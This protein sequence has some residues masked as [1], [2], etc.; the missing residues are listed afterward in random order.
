M[1]S[2][3]SPPFA[4][5]HPPGTSFRLGDFLTE[6]GAVLR[7][8]VL[9]YRLFGDVAEAPVRGWRLAF[10]DLG[11]SA[12]LD[13]WWP[14]LLAPGAPLDPAQG[15]VL[16]VNL[17]GSGLG[18]TGPRD[19]IGDR[20]GAFPDLTPADLARAHEPVLQHLGVARITLAIGPSLGGMVALE[21]AVG[22]PY[23]PIIWSSS[24][25]PPRR[26]RRRSRGILRSEWPSRPIP[27][28]K[29]A[30]TSLAMG[31]EAGMAAARALALI[32]RGSGPEFAGRSARPG[33]WPGGRFAGALSPRARPRTHH[34]RRR[35]LRGTAARD[36]SS[37]PGRPRERGPRTA[38]RVRRVTG[39][40]I[41]TD[42]LVPPAEVRHWESAYP[43]AGI[44]AGRRNWPRSTDTPPTNDAE[45]LTRIIAGI[46]EVRCDREAT[47]GLGHVAE[48]LSCESVRLRSR[49]A[50]APLAHPLLSFAA[51]LPALALPLQPVA[52][53]IQPGTPPLQPF[54]A[55]AV[56]LLL[57][58]GSRA[59]HPVA[60]PVQMGTTMLPSLTLPFHPFSPPL[61]VIGH[62][63]PARR[64]QGLC[65]AGALRHC[66]SGEQQPHQCHCQPAGKSSPSSTPVN[67][68][69]VGDAG[70]KSDVK[71]G[72]RPDRRRLRG[73]PEPGTQR[74]SPRAPAR[75]RKT[76]RTFGLRPSAFDTPYQLKKLSSAFGPTHVAE[77]T[78]AFSLIWRTRSRVMPRRPPI[79]SRVIGS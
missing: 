6:S 14:A 37:R 68:F 32:T 75:G 63:F 10:H 52:L 73:S 24:P 7:H 29:G 28:G 33:L 66:R 2:P 3:S 13:T 19:W 65:R 78:S 71:G 11:G 77:P 79:S 31:R 54:P 44:Q 35:K 8:T 20:L 22:A 40:G 41:N 55:G 43:A 46:Q 48:P 17:L 45:Q 30:A 1:S 64:S 16:A 23:R 56:A 60:F 53:P 47:G 26:P 4:S 49:R 50:V 51:P 12:D 72:S 42:M 18:S 59:L 76:P 58:P 38:R 36:G 39:I 27:H 9:R 74:L 34:R 15:P 25:R 21:W 5:A 67:G 69:G 61:H 62:R 57:E 70:G